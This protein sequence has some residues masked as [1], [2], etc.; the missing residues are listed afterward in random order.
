[1]EE[2]YINK[3]ELYNTVDELRKLLY[4]FGIRY[5]INIFEICDLFSNIEIATIPFK[6]PGL[7]G[8]A[9]LA[10]DENDVNCI[11]VN[12]NL[13]QEEQNF[14]GTHELMHICIPNNSRGATFRCY[15]K[16][17]PFQDKY[18]E[19]LANEGAAELLMPFKGFIPDFCALY[20]L[21]RENSTLWVKRFG[22][23]TPYEVL[24]NKY[25]V[26]PVSVK[27]RIKNLAYEIDQYI[28]GTKIDQIK[29]LS[30]TQRGRLGIQAND[31]IAIIDLLGAKY[32]FGIS[33]N[34]II[35]VDIE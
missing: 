18:L 3:K 21:Y 1:M 5:P 29:I 33:W 16:V 23:E 11:L 35:S 17:Q 31:Y 20:K 19:W 34:A 30:L 32:D 6:T 22:Y 8:M 13:T 4:S 25:R 2:I 26:S 12:S 7:R 9:K 28:K 15:E 24:A 10:D 14:H 27:N